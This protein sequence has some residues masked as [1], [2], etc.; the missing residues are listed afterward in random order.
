[1]YVCLGINSTIKV[2]D[3]D[4]ELYVHSAKYINTDRSSLSTVKALTYL[5]AAFD[6]FHVYRVLLNQSTVLADDLQYITTWITDL[7]NVGYNFPK[8][9][10]ISH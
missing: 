1:M 7:K 4:R 8:L 6:H 2:V 5:P 9:P 3:M 10:I